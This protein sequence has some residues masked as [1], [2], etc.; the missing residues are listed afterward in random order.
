MLVGVGNLARALLRYRGFEAQGF[1]IVALFDSDVAKQGLSI[2]G[3]PVF[4]LDALPQQVKLL[5]AELGVITVP[6]DAAQSVADA[7]V[8]AGVKGLL[9]FAPAIVQV[10][11]KVS[12]VGVDLSIQFEQLAFQVAASPTS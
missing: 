2:E 1:A 8:A 10:P 9:N 11:A 4:G 12:L 7:L 6:A 5:K 3:V